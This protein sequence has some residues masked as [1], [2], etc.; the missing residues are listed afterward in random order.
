M[1]DIPFL[2][3]ETSKED[4]YKPIFVKSSRKGNHKHYESNGDIEQ[5]LSVYQYLDIL[6]RI[7]MI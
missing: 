3:S 1:T 4:Y 7:Y 2:F 5:R 6:D